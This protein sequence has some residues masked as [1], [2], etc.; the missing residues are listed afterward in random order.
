[1]NAPEVIEDERLVEATTPGDRSRTRAREP[2]CLQRLES[3]LDDH[4]S[5]P[6]LGLGLSSR[7]KHMLKLAHQEE[8]ARSG[9]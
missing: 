8:S 1:V 9:A 7:F 4:G 3:R 6:H 2:L 5:R